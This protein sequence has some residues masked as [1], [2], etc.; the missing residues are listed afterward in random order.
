MVLLNKAAA[1]AARQLV[2]PIATTMLPLALVAAA[3]GSARALE[4][5]FTTRCP[6][7]ETPFYQ[8]LCWDAELIRLDKLLDETIAAAAEKGMPKQDLDTLEEK[9]ANRCGLPRDGKGPTPELRWSAAP[10]LAD[11]FRHRLRE[12][13]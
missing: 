1:I 2:L 7:T 6:H 3:S 12:L 9:A 4:S 10:C 13:G 8:T 5:H 11:E